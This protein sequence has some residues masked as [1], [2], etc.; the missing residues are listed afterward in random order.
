VTLKAEDNINYQE[1]KEKVQK[2]NDIKV[3]KAIP[4]DFST[5]VSHYYGL[6]QKEYTNLPSEKKG[7]MVDGWSS[8]K[9]AYI[10]GEGWKRP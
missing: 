1:K 5:F 4:I 2:K 6:N 8:F 10:K 7:R 9:R 3:A